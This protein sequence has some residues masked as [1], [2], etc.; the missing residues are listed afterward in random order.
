MPKRDLP[1]ALPIQTYRDPGT[2]AGRTAHSRASQRGGLRLEIHAVGR[3]HELDLIAPSY[4]QPLGH[5]SQRRIFKFC[6]S[7]ETKA[8]AVKGGRMGCPELPSAKFDKMTTAEIG[9]FLVVC[10]LASEFYFPAYYGAT[11]SKDSKLV[12]EAV[13]YKVNCE[14][15]LHDCASS[16]HLRLIQVIAELQ[17]I[18]QFTPG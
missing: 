1:G 11:S 7:E 8:K 4:F 5:D 12:R 6:T 17:F 14:R 10:A 18:P 9:K 3:H 15:I 13:H 2:I 16:G